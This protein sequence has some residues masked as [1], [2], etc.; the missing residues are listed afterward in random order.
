MCKR[1]IVIFILLFRMLLNDEER[2]ENKEENHC[3]DGIQTD[4]IHPTP[5]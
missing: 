2:V 3:A 4:I 5:S 1:K